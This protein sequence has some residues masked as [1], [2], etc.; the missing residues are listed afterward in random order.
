MSDFNVLLNEREFKS[1]TAAKVA[2]MLDSYSLSKTD[3][4]NRPGWGRQKVL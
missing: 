2:V 4:L 1:R 3:I